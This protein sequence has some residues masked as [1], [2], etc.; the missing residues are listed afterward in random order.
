M[1]KIYFK[2]FPDMQEKLEKHI[3]EENGMHGNNVKTM[4]ISETFVSNSIYFVFDGQIAQPL[5]II[6]GKVVKAGD[7]S[8]L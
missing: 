2:C 6:V 5:T 4:V 1:G 3:W 7:G 8:L